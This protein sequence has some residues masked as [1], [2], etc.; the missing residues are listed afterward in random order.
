MLVNIFFTFILFST[1]AV[2]LETKVVIDSFTSPQQNTINYPNDCNFSDFITDSSVLGN[3]RLISFGEDVI[4]N[5][6]FVVCD[7]DS[8][9]SL[10]SSIENGS[11]IVDAS[12]EVSGDCQISATYPGNYIDYSIN[13]GEGFR[14]TSEG[15][16]SF[17]IVAS[18][19]NAPVDVFI[20]TDRTELVAKNVPVGN[21][22]EIIVEFP[23]FDDPYQYY[24]YVSELTFGFR[25]YEQSSIEIHAFETYGP[26]NNQNP[27]PI[28]S[29]FPTN[30]VNSIYTIDN[31]GSTFVESGSIQSEFDCGGVSNELNSNTDIIGS[32]SV[33]FSA[34]RIDDSGAD[35]SISQA[36]GELQTSLTTGIKGHI[37][38]QYRD[39]N[40]ELDFCNGDGVLLRYSSVD[41]VKCIVYVISD[42]DNG[43]CEEPVIFDPE[44]ESRVLL[45]NDFTMQ[46]CDRTQLKSASIQCDLYGDSQEMIW[47]S[48]EYICSDSDCS[49]SENSSST[50][51]I[52]TPTQVSSST[53]NESPS[54]QGTPSFFSSLFSSLFSSSNSESSDNS[55]SGNDDNSS[56][57]LILPYFIAIFLINI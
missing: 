53:I 34:C 15:A 23:D 49:C 1:F 21:N 6:Y 3:G 18:V 40:S 16:T 47:K 57:T 51:D 48:F 8:S 7:N 46:D 12:N 31:F 4:A 38:F 43:V 22:Q 26:E 55:N 11:W 50:E 45:L 30:G 19:S 32:R 25:F 9:C 36:D 52:S 42:D 17:R 13:G 37:A 27:I 29:P 56:S 10:S 5:N 54:T 20:F 14:L 2:S 33:S 28:P 41:E 44:E 39:F 24:D 35:F